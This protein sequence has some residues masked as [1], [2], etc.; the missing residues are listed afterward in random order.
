LFKK[1]ILTLVTISFVCGLQA[2]YAYDSENN[3]QQDEISDESES[4]EKS[5]SSEESDTEFEDLEFNNDVSKNI[6]P[7]FFASKFTNIYSKTFCKQFSLTVP[8]S[9]P[10]A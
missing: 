2:S 4:S 8:T 7:L 3:T 10:N 9:P 1:F 5:E 6:L